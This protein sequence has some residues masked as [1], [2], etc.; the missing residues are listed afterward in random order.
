MILPI[1]ASLTLLGPP[2][3]KYPADAIAPALRE[4]AHA[5]VRAYDEKVVVKSASQ[6]V[7]TVHQV[8][9]VLNE[10]GSDEYGQLMVGY[11]ALN[12]ISYLRGAVY[13]A[14]GQLLHQLRQA[15]VHDQGLGSSGG[16]LMTD[17]RVRYADLRQPATPY[18]VEFD[19]EIV[20]ENTLFYPS[21]QPQSAEN[22]SLEGATLQVT[23]P[24]ALPLRYQEQLLPAG[25]ATTP[26]VAGAQTT[27]RWQLPAA[28]AVEEEPLS[29]PLD[30]LLPA[31]YLA[32][33]TF[34][35]QGHAGSL[36]SWQ[37]LGLWNYQ[38][39]QGR[40]ALPPALTAKMA[41]LLIEAPDP[42]ERARKVY[43]F[44]QGSTRYVS[45]QLGLGGW[46]TAPASSVAS[47]GY[48]DCKA[49][50]NYTCALL[51]AAGLPAYVALVGA[52]RNESDVRASFPSNQFNHMILCMPLAAHGS[53]PADTVWMECTSQTEAFGYMGAFTG[54]RH[55]LLLTPEGGRLVA[56]PR[57][58]AQA[59]RQLRR[60]DL[61]LDAT[62]AAKATVRTRRLGLA[63]D[64]YSQLLHEVGPEDQKKYV[65]NRLPLSHFTITS[66]RLAAAPT[67]GPVPLPGVVETM[68]LE[69]PGVGTA[70]GR[71]L[72]LEPNVLGRLAALPTQVGPRTAPLALPPPSLYQDTVRLH[73][74]A[75]FRAENLPQ[76]TQLAS[77]Y[78][79]YSSAC[80]TLPDG[81]LQY[82]RQLETRRPA[83]GTS[84]PA[85]KY[86][87]YQDFRRKVNQAD[88]AQLV[89]TKTDA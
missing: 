27:Y 4:N 39:G 69:L 1:F 75:G 36:A 34:E 88:H 13:N 54:N 38:L 8:V 50:S 89:L 35:V 31:V 21:W 12:H 11:D 85:A 16:S 74:P 49:L 78:G 25:A 73:L 48:G 71:R 58:G 5:V 7:K 57:Y 45:V 32:P 66:L 79:T 55:A 30:E 87:E 43:E 18:T 17:V 10:A 61:W 26:V 46:Q 56:T 82:V 42:R 84:L 19:Y 20:S 77:P 70:A 86:A 60:T 80:T 62:G 76:P 65:A 44:L 53:V 22:I 51:K 81:T 2:T 24:T 83:G 64:I 6:L 72:L 40:D 33:A 3:P 28:P 23:T 59:N 41:Q 63:Q 68:G 29:P 14:Q 52:G 9:T 67:T 37:S 15:E 47:G